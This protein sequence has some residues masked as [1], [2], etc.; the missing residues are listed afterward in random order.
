MV[1]KILALA[2]MLLVAFG[3]AP[4]FAQYEPNS[5]TLDRVQ[6]P[7]GGPFVVTSQCFRPGSTVTITFDNPAVTLGTLVANA[8]GVA[9]GT[10]TAPAGSS[11][12]THRV[13]STGTGCAGEA[14]TLTANIV[15]GTVTT[16]TAT[17]G[18]LPTTGS[19]STGLLATGAAGLL[20]VGGIFL[21]TSRRANRKA[22]V[23]NAR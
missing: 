14:L 17:T 12:G 3:A 22:A 11:T 13:T 8:N 23:T 9:T 1:K 4:A 2:V 19:S 6:T 7:P 10:F 20:A 18:T 5:M 15:V 21:I 16:T